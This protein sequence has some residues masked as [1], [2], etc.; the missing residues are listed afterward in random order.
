M[1]VS[2]SLLLTLLIGL[3]IG[4]LLRLNVSRCMSVLACVCEPV[5]GRESALRPVS[6]MLGI[7]LNLCASSVICIVE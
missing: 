6:S 2:Y 7:V 3:L 1:A 5:S 4:L